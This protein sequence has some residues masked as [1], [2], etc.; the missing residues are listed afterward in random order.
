VTSIVSELTAPTSAQSFL[1]LGTDAVLAARPATSVQ[2]AHACAAIGF[3]VVVPASW[4]DEIIAHSVALRVRDSAQPLVQCSCPL[5]ARR[6]AEYAGV[7]DGMMIRFVPP[8]IATARYV[9][10][11]YS[12]YAL[13]ITYAGDCPIGTLD[14]IDEQLSCAALS[15][16]LARRGIDVA[17]QP[18][19]FDSVIPPDRRRHFSEPGGVPS[20]SALQRIAGTSNVVELAAGDMPADLAQHLLDAERALLDIAPA[21]GCRCSGASAGSENVDARARVRAHE[22][23]RAATPVVDQEIQIPI[24]ADDVQSPEPAPEPTHVNGNGVTDTGGTPEPAL[25]AAG[26]LPRRRSP[27]GS[28]RSV[29]GTMPVSR[30]EGRQLP[31]LYVARRRS[32][33]RGVRQSTMRPM[34]AETL[35]AEATAVPRAKRAGEPPAPWLIVVLGIVVGV[36][37]TLLLAAIG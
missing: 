19:E 25:V 36:L 5:V 6:F 2:L 27:A 22:P 3:D 13:R 29:L 12:G 21:L 17:A 34:P 14:A 33:P 1:I 24:S 16:L 8:P 20:P 11:L 31:R 35:P 10:A 23:P 37:L 15:E 18:T 7:L 4:G 28:V 30:G 26:P 32:S 9:R